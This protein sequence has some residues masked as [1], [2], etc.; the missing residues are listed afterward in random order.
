MEIKQLIEKL[1]KNY[2]IEIIFTIV[3][4]GILIASFQA[5]N[6]SQTKIN[7]SQEVTQSILSGAITIDISGAVASPG[8]YTLPR[9]SRLNDALIK[10]GGLTKDADAQFFRRNYNLAK[11]LADQEKIYIPSYTETR[12]GKFK[13]L[14]V[15]VNSPPEAKPSKK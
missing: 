5:P 7:N 14:E 13:E 3:A 6:T 8:A 12:M 11:I 2:L 9:S 10:A 4:I 1:Y 15:I